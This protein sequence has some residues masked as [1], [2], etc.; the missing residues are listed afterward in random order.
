MLHVMSSA[1]PYACLLEM[2]AWI[3]AW[4]VDGHKQDPIHARTQ[5]HSVCW[6]I[7]NAG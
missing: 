3:M 6:H 7:W 1:L 4:C 2:P 5:K